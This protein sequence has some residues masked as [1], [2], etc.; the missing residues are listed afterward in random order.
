MTADN[1]FTSSFN[2]FT[3]KKEF[4]GNGVKSFFIKL[5]IFVVTVAAADVIIGG[6]LKKAYFNQHQGYDFLTTN[7]I[8]NTTAPV[9]IFG[10]S[11]AV[12]I[13]NPA[14]IEEELK[15]PCYNAGRVGQSVFYHYGVLKSVLK[16]YT[17]KKIIL[18]FDAGNFEKDQED[19]DRIST[20]LP[21]YK[22]VPEIESI[23][24][25]RGPFEELKTISYIYPYNSMLLPIVSGNMKKKNKYH[26]IKGYIPINKT[27]SGPLPAIDFTKAKNLDAKKI[28]IFRAFIIECN[29]ANIEL[30]VVCPPYLLEGFAND[31][32]IQTAKKIAS[33]YNVNFIDFSNDSFFTQ[34]PFL[35]ADFRH[36]N[37]KGSEIFTRQITKIINHSNINYSASTMLP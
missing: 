1:L 19:Y 9:L 33:D 35:F 17:P 23:V 12:N 30:H 24:G 2:I 11:R 18:S 34:Q 7:A 20:L 13:F 22:T 28:N 5:S 26:N 21:Y 3:M 10:S 36:L 14:L 4:S 37:E 25:L 31:L 15:L 32:S 8:K 6:V 29:R 27:I 16:R